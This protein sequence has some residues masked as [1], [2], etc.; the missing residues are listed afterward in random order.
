F[1]PARRRRSARLP[2]RSLRVA[3]TKPC[4]RGCILRAE[5]LA[6]ALSETSLVDAGGGRD[7]IDRGPHRRGGTAG[8]VHASGGWAR[9]GRCRS[10]DRAAHGRRGPIAH[11]QVPA[12]EVGTLL[13]LGV[14]CRCN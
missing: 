14:A 5:A 7:V 9:W 10:E 6:G 8:A 4:W 3:A 13:I 1:R 12:Y 2:F 11:D